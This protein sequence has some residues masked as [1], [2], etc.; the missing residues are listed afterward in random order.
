[1]V[2]LP[3]VFRRNG[4]GNVLTCVCPHRGEGGGGY[5]P[6][7]GGGYLPWPLGGKGVPTLAAGG[8]EG[9]GGSAYLGRGEGVLLVGIAG[10]CER[11]LIWYNFCGYKK[12]DVV[13]ILCHESSCSRKISISEWNTFNITNSIQVNSYEQD[14]CIKSE[15][16][17]KTISCGDLAERAVLDTH[18]L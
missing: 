11:G 5:L 12:N 4:E 16:P 3:S 8:G 1:M 7:M 9:W 13:G 6:L 14:T 15:G 17:P 18:D 10:T 2:L